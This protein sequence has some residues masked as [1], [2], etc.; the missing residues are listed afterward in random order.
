M[1]QFESLTSPV[2]VML[3][4][5][6]GLAA[7]V[8]ALV[9]AGISLNIYSQIG[10]IM[11]IG[12]MA[13]NGVLLVEFADQL[14]SEGRD[15]NQAV[16]DAATIRIRPIMMTVISTVLGA[17]PLILSSGAGAEA[18][19]SIGWVVFGGLGIAALFTLFLTPVVY[20]LIA[21]FTGSRGGQTDQLEAELQDAE[22]QISGLPETPA[23]MTGRS[24]ILRRP[25][26]SYVRLHHPRT[27]PGRAC[28]AATRTVPDRSAAHHR[29][30]RN[31]LVGGVSR[32]KD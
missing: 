11:L 27:G 6:F 25:D 23:M 29:R 16:L 22:D 1:A 8:Y 7:A 13:K 31:R 4:V 30:S 3:T 5:P 19:V 17:L 10:L 28:H 20:L 9:L 15:V 14:R 26:R 2:I 12:I 32:T 21:R 24:I 18:R